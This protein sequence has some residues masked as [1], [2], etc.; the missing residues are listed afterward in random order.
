MAI[1]LDQFLKTGAN[2]R[3]DAYGGSVANR[4]RLLLEV[5]TRPCATP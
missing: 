3:S 1:L 4:A 5:S 2:Q